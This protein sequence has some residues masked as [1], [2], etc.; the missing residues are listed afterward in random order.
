[1]SKRYRAWKKTNKDY[2][3][4]VTKEGFF[5]LTEKTCSQAFKKNCRIREKN[6]RMIRRERKLLKAEYNHTVN[7]NCFGVAIGNRNELADWGV[8]VKL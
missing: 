5:R 2:N 1:M 7:M 3:V 8:I 4:V 6:Q